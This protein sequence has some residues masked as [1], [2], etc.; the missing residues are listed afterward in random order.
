MSL[1]LHVHSFLHFPYLRLLEM[2][3][4]CTMLVP[5]HCVTTNPLHLTSVALQVLNF[6]LNSTFYAKHPI[7]EQQQNKAAFTA[8]TFAMCLSDIALN[9]V[10]KEDPCKPII[11]EAYSNAMN[12]QWSRHLLSHNNY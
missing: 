10:T 2:A 9:S 5:L 12:C 4:V 3:I 11:T 7:I 1:C 6:F 8:N